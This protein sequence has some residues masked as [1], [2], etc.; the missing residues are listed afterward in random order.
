[1]STSIGTCERCSCPI[2]RGD[3]RCAVCGL[4]TP[5]QEITEES[6][7]IQI[8]RCGGCGAAVSYDAQV[9]APTCAFCSSVMHT[10]ELVDPP[11]QTGAFLPFRV[12]HDEAAR[13]LEEWLGSRGF[14]R[15]SDLASQSKLEALQPILWVGWVFDAHCDVTWTADSNEGSRR[16]SWAPHSGRAR[17]AFSNLLVSASR[18]LTG[19]EID[20]LAPSYDLNDTRAE[21]TVECELEL[22]RIHRETFDVQRSAARRRITAAVESA[23]AA[24]IAADYVPGKRVRKVHTSVL[25][26]SLETRRLAFPAWVL[27]YR[28]KEKLYRAVVS[29]QDSTIM[30]GEAPLSIRRILMV[31]GLVI[32]GLLVIAGIVALSS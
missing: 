7:R 25:L 18:G 6:L 4:S 27:A 22:D 30:T 28:Y 10:E 21:P 13:G 31:V 2:E 5:P 29:G 32:L 1:M 14:F 17:I 26:S 16:S 11:E 24:E 23:A 19:D 3:L 15:P 8:L 20:V 12:S 9:G